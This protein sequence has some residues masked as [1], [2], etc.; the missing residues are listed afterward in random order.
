[1]RGEEDVQRAVDNALSFGWEP[2]VGQ[3]VLERHGYMAG[4]DEQRLADLNDALRDP[5]IDGV[6]CIRG[7]YGSLRLLPG[8]DFAA[9][10]EQGGGKALI[11]YSDA[12]ALHAAIQAQAGLISY[13]G[14]VAR[15]EITDFTRSSLRRAV[16][17]G[18]DP[19]GH[20]GAS[21]TLREGR[22]EGVL[23]G[24][25]LAVL[26]ALTGTPYAPDLSGC[27]LVLEDIDERTYRI[28]RMLRQ[29]Y[30]AGVLEGCRAIVFGECT[31]CGETTESG[32]RT[33][34][35][36]LGEMADLLDVP[37][38][39]GAPLGH[40]A[41]QWTL[42]LGAAAVLDTGAHALNVIT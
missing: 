12:T 34:D 16:V 41:D 20:A 3:H 2:V 42:P 39:A 36:V 10:R 9:L 27:I 14:P 6:W 21:R 23:A 32:T 35:E 28:D 33:L 40:I 8:I 1:L 17:E 37:C 18:G 38:L 25:N 19:A 13:H 4:S 24:G 30:L 22:A 29:L 31:N 26:T 7:G 11:G 15:A 5:S